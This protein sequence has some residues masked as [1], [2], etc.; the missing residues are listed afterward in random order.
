[1]EAKEVKIKSEN[2]TGIKVAKKMA[3]KERVYVF[4]EGVKKEE[5]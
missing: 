3:L 1:M 2:V 4:S 5:K